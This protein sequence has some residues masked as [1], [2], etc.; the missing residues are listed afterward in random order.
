MMTIFRI[1]KKPDGGILR[2]IKNK[3]LSIK[4]ERIKCV[5]KKNYRTLKKIFYRIIDQNWK[6]HIQYLN[7]IKTSYWTKIMEIEDP[8]I[9]YRKL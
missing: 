5:G 6:M 8:L 1:N 4:K 9:N 7:L 3:Y 2:L